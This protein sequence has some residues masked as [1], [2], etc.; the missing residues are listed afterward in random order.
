MP[1]ITT[2]QQVKEV[3]RIASVDSDSSLPD[4]AEAEQ[5]HIIPVIGKPLYNELLAAYEG[6]TLTTI[7]ETLLKKI[8]KPLAAFAYFDDL[9]LQHAMITDAG[10][11]RTT[12][13][14]MPSAYR[15]EF[16]GVKE[17]LANKAYQ[18]ME[19]LLEWLEENKTDF[20]TY[21]GSEA[22]TKVNKY[23]IKSGVDFSEQ[24]RIHQ[25][26]RT[27]NALISIMDDV[28]ILYVNALIGAEYFDELKALAAPTTLEAELIAFLKKAVAHLT[29]HHAFEKNSVKMTDSGPS[30]YDRYAD[31]GGS[32]SAQ[33]S[34]D[35]IKFSMDVTMRDG[36]TYLKKAKKLLDDN[37]SGSIFANYFASTYYSAPADPIDHNEGRGFYTFIK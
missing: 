29:I 34:A 10:V 11:R 21:T 32:E 31:R 37:A 7:Q 17:A 3:L 9:A 33:P 23:L 22:Y 4:I 13:D 30:I 12:T 18:G 36:Q 14:N 19:Y 8:Q 1:L 20:P 5:T 15:W 28:E 25:K 26:F 6:N 35:M 16:D 2:I 24:Y 27:Y